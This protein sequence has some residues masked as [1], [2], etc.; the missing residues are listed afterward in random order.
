MARLLLLNGPPGIGKST[1]ATRWANEH[2]G[3]LSCDIDVLRSL[4]GG[5]DLLAAG[6]LIRPAA[7]AMITAY[8]ESGHDV[9]LPRLL[10]R[11]EE[12]ERFERAARIA[13]AAF[14]ES[15]LMDTEKASIERFHRRGGPD[16]DPGS[17]P[18][19]VRAQVAAEGGDDL[20][21][22]CHRRLLMLLA[23]RPATVLV[24][25]VAGDLDGTYRVL[26]SLVD[27]S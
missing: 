12:L 27:G 26:V 21:A 24:D 5:V 25:S 19:R 13:G 7:L 4:V 11:L 15:L 6:E 20:L 14:V 17:W 8:L 23:A 16:A 18:A 2:P 22:D 9:V 1:M 10:T 3:V